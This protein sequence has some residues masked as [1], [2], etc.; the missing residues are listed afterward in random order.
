MVVDKETTVPAE[1]L[2]EAAER[3]NFGSYHLPTLKFD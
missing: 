2:M 1:N 3:Y